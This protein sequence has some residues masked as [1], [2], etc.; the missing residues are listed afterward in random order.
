MLGS[1]TLS[2]M[3]I[4]FDFVVHNPTHDETAAN[5]RSMDV[6]SAYFRIVDQ[7]SDGVIIP[8]DIMGEFT[9]IAREYS[10]KMQESRLSTTGGGGNKPVSTGPAYSSTTP[11]H[12][13]PEDTGGTHDASSTPRQYIVQQVRGGYLQHTAPGKVYENGSCS[14]SAGA[15]GVTEDINFDSFDEYLTY[16]TLADTASIISTG[17]QGSWAEREEG[18]GGGLGTVFGWA[19]PDWPMSFGTAVLNTT[20][21][22]A[23]V[24]GSGGG[25]VV[26]SDDLLL[27]H[28]MQA[29]TNMGVGTDV[30]PEFGL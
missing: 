21:Q 6:G 11:C 22:H 2:A 15:G 29:T 5:L 10:V 30:Y 23:G 24:G 19:F 27:F 20:E 14:S 28:Q 13:N 9:R 7:N 4:L 26:A 17:F 1:M 8:G 12:M 16:P 3:F 25:G 18:G